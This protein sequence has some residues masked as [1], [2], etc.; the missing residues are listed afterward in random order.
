LALDDLSESMGRLADFMDKTFLKGTET[1]ALR[2]K[3]DDA[4]RDDRYN[5]L[6]KLLTEVRSYFE[7][8][9]GGYYDILFC[10]ENNNVP[11]GMT[12][13]YANRVFRELLDD[14]F[15][16]LL[17]WDT[18]KEKALTT[19]REA[20]AVYNKMLDEEHER[21]LKKYPEWIG[22]PRGEEPSLGEFYHINSSW[23]REWSDLDRLLD[24]EGM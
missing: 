24:D 14:L 7:G 21:F 10:K 23:F 18:E 5:D 13:E 20:L 2:Q 16:N 12:K 3:I 6:K 8:W 19:Y 1:R 22:K 15:F 17:F 9:G 4:R 11:D